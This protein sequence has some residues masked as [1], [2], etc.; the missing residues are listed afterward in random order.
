[1]RKKQKLKF[2]WVTDIHYAF[3]DP[4]GNRYYTESILKLREAID[5]FKSLHLDFIIETGD[6]KDQNQP[7]VYEK[8]LEY[9]K[10]IE[11]EFVKYKGDRF[12]VLGNHDV[13][14]ISKEDFLGLV[15]NT[16]IP[17]VRSFY[18]FSKNGFKCIVLDACFRSDG[19]PYGK[20]NFDWTDV[21]IPDDQVVWLTG[22]LEKSNRPVL[23][24]VHQRLDGEG[25]YFVNNSAGVRA[26]LEKSG[27]VLAVFQG[28][29][30]EGA[31]NK[32]NDIHYITQKAVI[33]GSGIQNNSYSVVTVTGSGDIRIDGYRM[34]EDLKI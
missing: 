34:M 27:K 25:N 3:A 4:K 1:L 8:T 10:D 9:L 28:H 14:S 21:L 7:P 17:D 24:F 6:F 20:G 26:V 5:L 2:G 33:E 11:N 19:K 13:D 16:G 30:H 22:E 12:H 31:Y 29:Y 23:I 32:I 18:S 15:E